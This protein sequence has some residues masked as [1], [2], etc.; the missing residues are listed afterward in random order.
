MSLPP[1]SV[2]ETLRACGPSFP[3][4]APPGH[5]Y[6][7][8]WGS[9]FVLSVPVSFQGIRSLTK[10]SPPSRVHGRRAKPRALVLV[11]LRH[12]S[13]G[14]CVVQVRGRR[15]WCPRPDEPAAQTIHLKQRKHVEENQGLE[16]RKANTL[17]RIG[18]SAE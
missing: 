6:R 3:C 16:R 14:T 15:G 4:K 18:L 8:P 2:G 7:M 17:A 9:F 11:A 1:L 13:R 12:S 5:S 10:N